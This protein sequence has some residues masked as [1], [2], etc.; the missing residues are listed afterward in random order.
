MTYIIWGTTNAVSLQDEYFLTIGSH[1]DEPSQAFSKSIPWWHHNVAVFQL[2]GMSWL[3]DC[4][5]LDS[6]SVTPSCGVKKEYIVKWLGMAYQLHMLVK[7]VRALLFMWIVYSTIVLKCIYFQFCEMY[8][9]TSTSFSTGWLMHNTHE[10]YSMR[11]ILGFKL[12]PAPSSTV[13]M[14]NYDSIQFVMPSDRQIMFSPHWSIFS[15]STANLI[16]CSSLVEF[17]FL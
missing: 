8:T 14:L 5:R 1:S 6:A 4:I 10:G 3:M 2:A 13:L 12:F 11:P 9:F 15:I 17:A 16:G 7:R